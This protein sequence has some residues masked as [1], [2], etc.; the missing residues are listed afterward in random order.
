MDEGAPLIKLAVFGQPVANS[1]SPRIHGLFATQF[2]LPVEYR[3]IEST[4]ER[5]SADVAALA[6]EGGRGCNVT[7]PFKKAAW[8]LAARC[9]EDANRAGAANTLVFTPGEWFADSTDGGGLAGDLEQGAGFEIGGS[10]ICLLGAGGAA[11]SVLAALLR[12]GPAGI[13]IANRTGE[14]AAR[15]AAGHADLGP[16]AA[17]RLDE[18]AARGPFDLVINATSLG[19][20]GESPALPPG[21]F[22]AGALCYDMNYGAAAAPLETACGEIGVRYS[23]GLGMLVGQAA[24]SF[25]IWTGKKPDTAPVLQALRAAPGE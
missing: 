12:R 21:L 8:R 10:R 1:L 2:G 23:D 17:A 25:A 20:R 15:L 3:A 16:V 22:A 14:K 6:R 24:L 4:P 5:F 18:L 9:S 7:V 19:H 11:G 13:V